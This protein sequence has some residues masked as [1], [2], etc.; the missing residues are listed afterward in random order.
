MKVIVFG[1]T[2]DV[3]NRVVREAVTRG[4]DVTAVVRNTKKL[5]RLPAAASVRTIDVNDSHEVITAMAGHDLAVTALRPP[6][7]RESDLPAMTK[8]VLD[9]AAKTQT[10]LL[11]VGG[12][13]N[14]LLPDRNGQTVLTAPD[15]LPD[16]WKPIATA[17]QR[18]Y[19][20]CLAQENVAW[21]YFSPPAILE[22][23]TR[24][25][26]YRRGSDTLLIDETGESRIS[27]E[28]FAVAMMD[29]AET[30][31]APDSRVTVAY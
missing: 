31:N 8:S 7:G 24:T 29:V 30:P 18:Q 13:A 3:G 1:A 25:G 6:E 21:T 19:E 17:C 16:A 20:N 22:P 12:A 4:H 2:G 28:D 5:D 15:F 14:L 11:V 26:K 23:G 27:M 9:A 10:R